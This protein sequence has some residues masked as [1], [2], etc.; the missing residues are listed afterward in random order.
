MTL[1]SPCW[2]WMCGFG[3]GTK[4]TSLSDGS[5]GTT[6]CL[7]VLSYLSRHALFW[8]CCLMHESC[9]G[10]G[11]PKEALLSRLL[12]TLPTVLSTLTRVTSALFSSGVGYPSLVLSTSVGCP[13][14]S[15][16]AFPFLPP[17]T[18]CTL[19]FTRARGDMTQ[20][21]HE[22]SRWRVP[23]ITAQAGGERCFYFTPLA[24]PYQC[25]QWHKSSTTSATC[26]LLI[27]TDLF[28]WR[29]HGKIFCQHAP[30]IAHT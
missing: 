21:P 24:S 14:L 19:H 7:R 17:F 10:F 30:P 11:C 5:A 27:C 9:S 16:S 3:M 6:A 20:S 13:W 23:G 28:L 26:S 8:P 22:P 15:Y 25:W 12:Y 2:A 18:S 29:I 4:N 1:L